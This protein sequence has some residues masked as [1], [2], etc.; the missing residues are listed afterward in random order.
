MLRAAPVKYKLFRCC[1]SSLFCLR[2]LASEQLRPTV[3]MQIKRYETHQ[4]HLHPIFCK[5][6]KKNI[7]KITWYDSKSATS[8]STFSRRSCSN[9]T[10]TGQKMATFWRA[11]YVYHQMLRSS[12]PDCRGAIWRS[13]AGIR[14]SVERDKSKRRGWESKGQFYFPLGPSFTIGGQV[15]QSS[16][17]FCKK[18]SPFFKLA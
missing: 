4:L 1:C 18:V 17:H 11:C 5:Q 14:R 12:G 2:A 13:V 10:I 3:K 8:K 15:K 9:N 7:Y 16:R 6:K